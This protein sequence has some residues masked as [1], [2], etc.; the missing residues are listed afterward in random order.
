MVASIILFFTLYF[1]LKAEEIFYD[2][3]LHQ[4]L[5]KDYEPYALPNNGVTN[6]GIRLTVLGIKE[7]DTMRSE[8]T[9]IMQMGLFW[10]DQ[11]LRW[12]PS[13][14]GGLNETRLNAEPG[15]RNYIWTPDV[16]MYEDGNIRLYDSFKRD[17]VVLTNKGEAEMIMKG[18]LTVKFNMKLASYPYDEQNITMSFDLL[19]FS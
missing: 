5:L 10:N 13:D 1:G 4:N 3:I 19:H 14:Y 18:I 7:V 9:F 12:D 2:S 17:W 6:V 8:A 15:N 16:Q 11:R